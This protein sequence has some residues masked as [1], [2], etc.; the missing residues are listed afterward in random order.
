MSNQCEKCG[1]KIPF[2]EVTHCSDECLFDG[3]ETTKS[4]SR[5]P[6]EEWNNNYWF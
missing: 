3:L 6:F 2:R 5:T 1:K 4:I